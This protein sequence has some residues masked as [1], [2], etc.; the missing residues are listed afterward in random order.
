[1][2]RMPRSSVLDIMTVRCLWTPPHVETARELWAEDL[3]LGNIG[4]EGI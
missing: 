3:S 4:T 2:R 1:M